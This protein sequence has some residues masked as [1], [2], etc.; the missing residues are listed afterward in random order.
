[1]DQMSILG[2]G[3]MLVI[4]FGR[5]A[6]GIMMLRNEFPTAHHADFCSWSSSHSCS[7]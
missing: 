2:I 1:M 3:A 4:G 6:L 7:R 5:I